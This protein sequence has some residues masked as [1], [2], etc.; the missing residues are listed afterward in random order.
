MD[1]MRG[2]K[3]CSMQNSVYTP[4]DSRILWT[5]RY[6]PC[7]MVHQLTSSVHILTQTACV[8]VMFDRAAVA[9]A[10]RHLADCPRLSGRVAG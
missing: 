3:I 10:L 6:L 8:H 7:I 1:C 5:M 4:I 9:K 2:S